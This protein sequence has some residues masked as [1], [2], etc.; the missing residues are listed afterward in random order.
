L[1]WVWPLLHNI[2]ALIP[3]VVGCPMVVGC[4]Y[5]GYG[6]KDFLVVSVIYAVLFR[7]TMFGIIE[8][9]FDIEVMELL[10]FLV[11]VMFGSQTKS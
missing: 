3:V 1:G 7:A 9:F 8:A 6:L 11:G 10:K 5:I 2:L 4:L